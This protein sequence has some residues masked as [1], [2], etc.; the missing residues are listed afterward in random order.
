MVV[1]SIVGPSEVLPRKE[2]VTAPSSGKE[3]AVRR[4]V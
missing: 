1:W 3:G 2:Y 4:L